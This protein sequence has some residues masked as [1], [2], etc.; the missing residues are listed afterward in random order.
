MK[1][2]LEMTRGLVFTQRVMLALIDKGLSRQKAYELVQRSA[3]KSW[4]GNKKFLTLLKADPEVTS[5]LPGEELEALFDYQYYLRYIDDI[6]LRLGLTEA[7]WKDKLGK[8][9]PAELAPRA[10]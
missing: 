1:R 5:C 9:E 10:L 6:F 7:Q 4:E 3:M 2:N 8:I